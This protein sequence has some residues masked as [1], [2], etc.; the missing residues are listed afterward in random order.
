MSALSY[1]KEQFFF[2]LKHLAVSDGPIQKRLGEA[3]SAY[4]WKLQTKHHLPDVIREEYQRM[5][6]RMTR[7]PAAGR[8]TSFTVTARQMTDQE[9][10]DAA[11]WIA[12]TYFK[13]AFLE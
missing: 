3:W 4:L 5:S 8:D 7:V 6:E 13:L 11:E 1:A 12:D 10:F 9:A 2:A